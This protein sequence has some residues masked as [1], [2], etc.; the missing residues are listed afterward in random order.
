MLYRASRPRRLSSPLTLLG[1][2]CIA[3]V[4]MA[5]MI[6]VAHTH[7]SGQPSHDCSLCIVAHQVVQ[8]VAPITLA[9]SSQSVAAPA[10]EPT[11]ELPNRPL[12]F[13]LSS[14]PPPAAPAFV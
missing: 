12:F 14:R 5:G 3:L 8:V 7:A 6:Q 11:R 4:L 2:V 10:V 13:K 1:I 9:L